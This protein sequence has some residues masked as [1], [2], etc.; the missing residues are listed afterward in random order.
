MPAGRDYYDILGVSRHAKADEIRKAFRRKA[1]ECHPDVSDRP[2]AERIFKEINEAYQV[3]GDPLKRSFY[4]R[5]GYT[6]Y[7][8]PPPPPPRRQPPPRQS[9]P[10]PPPPPHPRSRRR[11]SRSS[12]RGLPQWTWPFI[13]MFLIYMLCPLIGRLTGSTTGTPSVARPVSSDD[14][15]DY[16]FD[17][18]TLWAVYPDGRLRYVALIH[19]E[20]GRA[21]PPDRLVFL[22]GPPVHQAGDV[23]SVEHTGAMPLVVTLSLDDGEVTYK[24]PSQ[25]GET[26]AEFSGVDMMVTDPACIWTVGDNQRILVRAKPQLGSGRTIVAV[27]FPRGVQIVS[28]LD[29]QPYQRTYGS[30]RVAYFN[31]TAPERICIDYRFDPDIDA[32]E[33]D[34]EQVYAER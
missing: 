30:W 7:R 19:T 4:D 16:L 31:V 10:P 15:R 5:T 9:P 32:P 25:G 23:L 12:R 26:D 27:A 14:D 18:M 34:I 22:T 33:L 17:Q 29:L 6:S 13:L 2:D 28:Y 21:T 24:W 11:T 20:G 3:L 1:R 8:R